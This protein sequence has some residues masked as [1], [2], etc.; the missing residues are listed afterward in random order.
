MDSPICQTFAASPAEP[1][2]S[3]CRRART[4]TTMKPWYLLLTPLALR[5]PHR[6]RL[7]R[8]DRFDVL[9]KQTFCDRMNRIA[10]E[11]L[12]WLRIGVY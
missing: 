6:Q 8:K 1:G 12:V 5:R 3:L 10:C 11:Q 7:H 9:S 4:C 2:A